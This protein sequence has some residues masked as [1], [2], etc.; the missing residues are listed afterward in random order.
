MGQFSLCGTVSHLLAFMKMLK[1]STL[2]CH[3]NHSLFYES[4]LLCF[5]ICQFCAE[6]LSSSP[7]LFLLLISSDCFVVTHFAGN[8]DDHQSFVQRRSLTRNLS[9]KGDGCEVLGVNAFT[10]LSFLF[11]FFSYG[12][13]LS[14]WFIFFLNTTMC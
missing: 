1:D 4:N 12:F 10:F 9:H 11:L 5:C 3:R 14:L 8:G 6:V 13:L 7:S 2:I